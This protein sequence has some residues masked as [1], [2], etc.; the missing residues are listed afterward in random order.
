MESP[1][2]SSQGASSDVYAQSIANG[3]AT[4]SLFSSIAQ[5]GQPLAQAFMKDR[6]DRKVGMETK[7]RLKK[8]MGV[9]YDQLMDDDKLERRP[10]MKSAAFR[11]WMLVNDGAFKPV[12]VC[13][14][15]ASWAVL[16]YALGIDPTTQVTYIHKGR[17]FTESVVSYTPIALKSRSLFTGIGR[18]P[19]PDVSNTGF[20]EIPGEIVCHIINLFCEAQWGFEHKSD[21]QKRDIYTDFGCLTLT[22]PV[23]TSERASLNFQQADIES[24][25]RIRQPLSFPGDT[26]DWSSDGPGDLLEHG[27]RMILYLQTLDTSYGTSHGA[28]VWPT[29][30]AA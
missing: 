30:T 7:R 6:A 8:Y 5:F 19:A 14:A 24:V 21:S 25:S 22:P 3:Q 4:V 15:T 10:V 29:L 26:S 17:K 20:L 27:T 18:R 9:W 13:T 11:E 16:L 12:G 1:P 2:S 23:K 28:L